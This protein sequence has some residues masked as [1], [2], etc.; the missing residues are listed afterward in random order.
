MFIMYSSINSGMVMMTMMTM[1][2]IVYTEYP[3]AS[4]IESVVRY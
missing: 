4:R 1:M 3:F 2:T